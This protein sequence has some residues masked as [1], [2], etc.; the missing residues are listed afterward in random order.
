MPPKTTHIVLLCAILTNLSTIIALLQLS[1]HFLLFLDKK[2]RQNEQI[3]ISTIFDAN[4]S[5]ARLHATRRKLPEQRK[6]WMNPGRTSLW[7][8]NL[9]NGETLEEEWEKMTS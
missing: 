4:R 6:H 9:I 7:W 3:A 2:R 5:T 8:E 1:V